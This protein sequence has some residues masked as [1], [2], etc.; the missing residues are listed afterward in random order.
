DGYHLAARRPGQFVAVGVSLDQQLRNVLV[1]AT[2]RKVG[3]PPGGGYGII[4]RNQGPLD[5]LTQAGNYLV[6]EVG[7]KG[8]VG[9]WRGQDNQWVDIL[10][11]TPAPAVQPGSSIDNALEVRAQDD[12][13]T[14]GVNGTVMPVQMSAQPASGAVGVFLGGDGNEAVL[15]RLAVTRLD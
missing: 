13:L 8:E 11:W 3:G 10:A 1:S 9:I 7:D 4:V 14:F 12:A 15:S 6:F 2:F 5:G